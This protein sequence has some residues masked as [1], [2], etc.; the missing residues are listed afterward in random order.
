[1]LAFSPACPYSRANY[2][3]WT[4]L[5]RT[6]LGSDWTVV[7]VT[8]APL[9]LVRKYVTEFP[10]HDRVLVEV[11][12]QTHTLLGLDVVPATAAVTKEGKVDRVWYGG[13]QPGDWDSLR[14]YAR[15]RTVGNP[16]SQGEAK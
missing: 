14:A 10:I 7:W 4:E 16:V 9:S 11:P 13:L 5:S 3:R 1:V 6:L 12:A 8:P 15:Q 2:E